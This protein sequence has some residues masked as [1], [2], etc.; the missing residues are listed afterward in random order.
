MANRYFVY[1]LTNTI[2]GVL[3]VGMTND[4]VRRLG[5]HRSGAVLSFTRDYG[6]HRLVYFE[7][8]ASVLEAKARERTLKRWRRAWKFQLIESVNPD[9]RD[10][11]L[12]LN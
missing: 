7:E 12:E 11:S 9:W 3:Y 2:R 4:L 1:I 10:L 8:Y 6:L 5:Q